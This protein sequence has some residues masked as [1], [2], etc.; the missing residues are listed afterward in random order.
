MISKEDVRV[1]SASGLDKKQWCLNSAGGIK[2]KPTVPTECINS[3]VQKRYI[4]CRDGKRA[5]ARER[6]RERERAEGRL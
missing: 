1:E 2:R 5:R 6:E 4:K 3:G